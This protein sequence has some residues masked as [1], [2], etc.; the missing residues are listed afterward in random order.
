MR[1]HFLIQVSLRRLSVR[2]QEAQSQTKDGDTPPILTFDKDDVDT[3]D[4]VAASANLRSLVFGIETRS[5]FDIKRELARR[6]KGYYTILMLGRNG[7]KHYTRNCNDE[8]HDCRPLRFASVQSYAAGLR[9]GENGKSILRKLLGVNAI[10][11]VA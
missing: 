11:T 5:K 10:L 2:L 3:L 1:N 7:W 9:K 4:F 6:Y 8:C